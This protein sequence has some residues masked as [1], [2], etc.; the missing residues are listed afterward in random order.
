MVEGDNGMHPS[1]ISIK[2][3][4]LGIRE[5]QDLCVEDAFLS[6]MLHFYVTGGGGDTVYVGLFKIIFFWCNFVLTEYLFIF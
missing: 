6:W 4:T 3:E 2:C 5:N 1:C